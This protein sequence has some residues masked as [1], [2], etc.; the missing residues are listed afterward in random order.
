MRT[1][2]PITGE[3]ESEEN[4][5]SHLHL[6]FSTPAMYYAASSG[7][8]SLC[9]T[10]NIQILEKVFMHYFHYLSIYIY[11]STY[12]YCLPIMYLQFHELL[13]FKLPILL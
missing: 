6:S 11:I 8:L 1:E 7:C 10:T 5:S 12:I 2:L 13:R 3:V 9:S 4:I